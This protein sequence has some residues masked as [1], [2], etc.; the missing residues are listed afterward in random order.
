MER[1]NVLHL[2]HR[3][4]LS[5]VTRH[6]WPGFTG[7]PPLGLPAKREL[8]IFER[9]SDRAVQQAKTIQRARAIRNRRGEV[10]L[11]NC[12][13]NTGRIRGDTGSVL[14]LTLKGKGKRARFG[15]TGHA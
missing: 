14:I 10:R 12:F 6:K 4:R 5:V 15:V 3:N 7:P 8:E 9:E 11:G 13:L 2:K 1:N